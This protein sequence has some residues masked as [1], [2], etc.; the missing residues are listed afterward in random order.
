MIV[1]VRLYRRWDLDLIAMA[2]A[3]YD[4][5]KMIKEALMSYANGV[6]VQFVIDEF[7]DFSADNKKMVRMRFSIPNSDVNTCYMLRHIKQK[8]R[9]NFC[10]MLF[11]NCLQQQNLPIYFTDEKL[12]QLHDIDLANKSSGYQSAPVFATSLK[13]EN[14]DFNFL[15]RRIK[16]DNPKSVKRD[17]EKKEQSNT[18]STPVIETHSEESIVQEK[19]VTAP[20]EQGSSDVDEEAI[21]DMFDAL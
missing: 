1:E 14:K 3:G 9:S 13:N 10:K 12:R 7:T 15:G 16:V 20:I 17:L 8:Q 4:M 19:A 18:D 5:T 21:M 6:K 11:R 2:D